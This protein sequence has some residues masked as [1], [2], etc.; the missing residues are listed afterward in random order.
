MSNNQEPPGKDKLLPV[1]RR[2]LSQLEKAYRQLEHYTRSLEAEQARLREQLIEAE[3]ELRRWQASRGV[4]L[5][6]SLGL[7]GRNLQQSLAVTSGLLGPNRRHSITAHL[8]VPQPGAQVGGELTVSGWAIGNRLKIEVWL[9]DS[10]LG[11]AEYNLAR[12]DVV[13][14]RPWLSQVDCGF[15]GRFLLDPQCFQPGPAILK[16]RFEDGVS[17]VRELSCPLN[18]APAQPPDHQQLYQDWIERTGL[19]GWDFVAQQVASQQLD[20]RPTISLLLEP[21]HTTSPGL[22]REFLDSVLAQTYGYWEVW[23][24]GVAGDLLESPDSRIHLLK[25]SLADL[26]AHCQGE[27]LTL[28]EPDALLGQE[29]LF[30]LVSFLNRHRRAALVY[31]DE[32]YL[33]QSG[34]RSQPQFKPDWSPELFYSRPYTGQLTLY[35]T[36]EVR[37]LG[38]TAVQGGAYEL[39]LRLL[40][41]GAEFYH[42]PKVIYH[43]RHRLDLEQPLSPVTLQAHFERTG[44][45][46]R[47]KNGLLAGSLRWRYHLSGQPAIS[48]IVPTRDQSEVLRRCLDSILER[49]S[50][51]N[52]EIVVVDNASHQPETQHYFSEL[53]SNPRIRLLSFDGPFNYSAINNFAAARLESELL[54]FLNNDTEVIT[55]DWLEEL[56]SYAQQPEIGASGARLLYPNDTVQHAGVV[57]GLQGVADHVLKG[58]PALA[59]GYLGLAKTIKN[60]SALTA[61]CLMTRRELFWQVGG[62]DEQNLPVAFN[63]VDFCLKLREQGLRLVWTPYAELYHHEALSRGPDFSIEKESRLHHEISYMFGRWSSQL[64]RDPYYNPNLSL[65]RLDYAVSERCNRWFEPEK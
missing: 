31:S 34:K 58:L 55:P 4:R 50:Y 65:D 42:L 3:G 41:Q 6:R 19:R 35:R 8:D 27:Y 22:L 9:N 15:V 53:R 59:P 43:R 7:L 26:V 36:A 14:A 63:D 17:S 48:I 60:V 16:V 37:A 61:A 38:G 25:A 40:E 45:A 12:W 13:K 21:N 39:A 18:I 62:F 1:L 56:A 5:G 46:S 24:G 23:L 2:R 44:Q 11:L 52:Y 30:E 10:R 32:D 28:P 33:D 20:Y 29:A 64:A 57:V 49:S 51:P 54:V 47:P